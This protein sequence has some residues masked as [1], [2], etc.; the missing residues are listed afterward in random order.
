MLNYDV[1]GMVSGDWCI[2]RYAKHLR[3]HVYQQINICFP[4]ADPNIQNVPISFFIYK[5]ARLFQST[6]NND[7]KYSNYEIREEI[8][9]QVIAANL[10]ME[11]V[12][13]RNLSSKDS[14][15]T[16]FETFTVSKPFE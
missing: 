1:L 11:N 9:S 7:E 13:I 16:R 8:A 10:E 15:V 4:S 6:L 3:E 14:V 12:T 2:T 5:D